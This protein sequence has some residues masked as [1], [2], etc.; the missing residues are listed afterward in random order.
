MHNNNMFIEGQKAAAEWKKKEG[1]LKS[2]YEQDKTWR[3]NF[4]QG[5]GINTYLDQSVHNRWGSN[6][7]IRHKAVYGC[8]G[9]SSHGQRIDHSHIW[10][11]ARSSGWEVITRPRNWHNGREKSIKTLMVGDM[12]TL[13]CLL[14][15][16]DCAQNSAIILLGGG[17]EEFLDCI[18]DLTSLGI[19]VLVIGWHSSLSERDTKSMQSLFRDDLFLTIQLQPECVEELGLFQQHGSALGLPDENMVVISDVGSADLSQ[20]MDSLHHVWFLVNWQ[21]TA[22]GEGEGPW[23]V[24]IQNDFKTQVDF[25]EDLFTN[26]V[27]RSIRGCPQ[28]SPIQPCNSNSTRFE[29]V[30]NKSCVNPPMGFWILGDDSDDDDNTLGSRTFED[31]NVCKH[32]KCYLQKSNDAKVNQFRTR[33]RAANITFKCESSEDSHLVVSLH[34]NQAV[35]GEIVQHLDEI[36][37]LLRSLTDDS[38][39]L[40]GR[41]VF[42][43]PMIC[44]HGKLYLQKYDEANVNQFR[45]RMQ[46]ANLTFKCE[47]SEDSHLVV[48]LHGNQAASDE[49]VEWHLDE[50]S[51][52]LLD[53][54]STSEEGTAAVLTREEGH[55][56]LHGSKECRCLWKSSQHKALRDDIR[57]FVKD[58]QALQALVVVVHVDIFAKNEWNKCTVRVCGGSVGVP[59]RHRAH[60][61]SHIQNEWEKGLIV[62]F[63]EYS[64]P[65]PPTAPKPPKP[66]GLSTVWSS[67]TIPQDMASSLFKHGVYSIDELKRMNRVEIW[68][69]QQHPEGCSY[70]CEVWAYV[71]RFGGSKE[72][73]RESVSRTITRIIQLCKAHVVETTSEVEDPVLQGDLGCVRDRLKENTQITFQPQDSQNRRDY[74]RQE[75]PQS[76]LEA[77]LHACKSEQT[78]LQEQLSTGELSGKKNKDKRT[79]ARR[80]LS[81]LEKSIAEIMEKIHRPQG[82][83]GT[84]QTPPEYQVNPAPSFAVEI[85]G[86]GGGA[87]SEGSSTATERAALDIPPGWVILEGCCYQCFRGFNLAEIASRKEDG[88]CMRCGGDLITMVHLAW[89]EDSPRTLNTVRKCPPPPI[90]KACP[91]QNERTGGH[92]IQGAECPRAHNEVELKYW[93]ECCVSKTQTPWI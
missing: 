6:A 81:R 63:P 15:H 83:P 59:Q 60:V 77:Q 51:A 38:R 7:A 24:A 66:S 40:Q 72:M 47:S 82:S 65:S 22:P 84:A 27:L 61:S 62:P 31:P 54:N 36:S 80:T 69:D 16:A 44:K 55:C 8:E 26:S 78:Q 32:G 3:V 68:I 56:T 29:V 20:L 5:L 92:C 53:F 79:K 90:Q 48:S 21:D 9:G 74:G 14:W 50:I 88:T 41:K 10:G 34:G 89:K 37:A 73:A 45:T 76:E 1:K 87:D 39:T 33:M 75:Y 64:N 46:A 11:A 30:P 85:P 67:T 19:E 17:D 70:P 49:D 93:S 18:A 91:Y 58:S 57:S 25:I 12:K 23:T 86:Q 52:L 4:Q 71:S 43:E 28:I 13:G 42:K 2:F 35:P